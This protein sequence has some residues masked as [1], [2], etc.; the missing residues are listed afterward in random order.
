MASLTAHHPCRSANEFK[1]RSRNP[2]TDDDQRHGQGEQRTIAPGT[3]SRWRRVALRAEDHASDVEQGAGEDAS[4]EEDEEN[5]GKNMA[6]I[7][8]R[9]YNEELALKKAEG[10]HA[11]DCQHGHEKDHSSQ[12]HGPDDAAFDPGEQVSAE[13]LRDVA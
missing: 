5:A 2:E 8:C 9:T 7:K 13:M 4:A 6:A 3:G 10:R 11:D 1:Q 12:R